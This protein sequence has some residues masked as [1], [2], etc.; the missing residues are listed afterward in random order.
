MAEPGWMQS[1]PVDL[2]RG[3]DPAITPRSGGVDAAT[4]H[5]K[6][7]E[8]SP[9]LNPPPGSILPGGKR[10]CTWTVERQGGRWPRL[11]SRLHFMMLFTSAARGRCR[12]VALQ[13]G[14]WALGPRAATPGARDQSQLV[15]PCLGHAAGVRQGG[16][17]P[18]EQGRSVS[19]RDPSEATGTLG[20]DGAPL[21][22]KLQTNQPP[23]EPPASASVPL[24]PGG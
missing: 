20:G 22:V 3:P 21:L 9:P 23:R 17:G 18:R 10:G 11:S 7:L 6:S 4:V 1:R 8:G 2:G 24:V 13:V 12:C 15:S 16:Q 14:K 19:P 5:S